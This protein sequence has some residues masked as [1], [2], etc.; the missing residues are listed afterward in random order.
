MAQLTSLDLGENDIGAAG[1][2]SLAP[3]LAQM[4][5]PKD[6]NLWGNAIGDA[7]AESLAPSLARMGQLKKLQ[8]SGNGISAEAAARLPGNAE[9]LVVVATQ[10]RW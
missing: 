7:G 8:F 4:T 10:R 6:L 3:S 1:A 2:A 5:R 9:V